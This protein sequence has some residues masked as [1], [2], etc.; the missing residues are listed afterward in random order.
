MVTLHETSET[1]KGG[2]PVQT[3]KARLQ[4]ILSRVTVYRDDRVEVTYL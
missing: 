3:A 2:Q 4:T 1:R